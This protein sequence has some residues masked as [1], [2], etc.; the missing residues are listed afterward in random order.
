MRFAY[1]YVYANSTQYAYAKRKIFA[2]N[3]ML[4]EDIDIDLSEVK[5]RLKAFPNWYL[6]MNQLYSFVINYDVNFYW[7]MLIYETIY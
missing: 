6:L 4:S 3:C 1:E 2:F 7:I 5:N